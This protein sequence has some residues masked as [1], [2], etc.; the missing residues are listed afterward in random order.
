MFYFEYFFNKSLAWTRLCFS[1]FHKL[2]CDPWIL[3]FSFLLLMTMEKCFYSEL[4][5]SGSQVHEGPL[6]TAFRPIIAYLRHHRLRIVHDTNVGA[7]LKMEGR[8]S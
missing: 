4:C 8:R 3:G 5:P 6:V 1:S 7:F 2:K